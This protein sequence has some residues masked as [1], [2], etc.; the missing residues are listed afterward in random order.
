MGKNKLTLQQ[1]ADK[2]DNLTEA[3]ESIRNALSDLTARVGSLER[4]SFGPLQQFIDRFRSGAELNRLLVRIAEELPRCTSKLDGLLKVKYDGDRKGDSLSGEKSDQSTRLAA[5]EALG[6]FHGDVHQFAVNLEHKVIGEVDEIVTAHMCVKYGVADDPDAKDDFLVRYFQSVLAK[7]LLFPRGP[8]ASIL[9]QVQ[10]EL[11]SKSMFPHLP[12]CARDKIF[13]AVS[14]AVLEPLVDKAEAVLRFVSNNTTPGE[15]VPPVN[16]GERSTR[17][18]SVVNKL[19]L[20]YVVAFT[21]APGYKVEGG[22]D[23]QP[24]VWARPDDRDR[25][26]MVLH[27]T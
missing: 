19:S 23:L 18:C 12:A 14:L 26:P 5:R 20:P 17:D 22:F 13:D 10:S 4:T 7:A 24:Q 9:E 6:R 25:H 3:L 21:V 16:D 2:I 11:V 1:V 15:L 27:G 8:R